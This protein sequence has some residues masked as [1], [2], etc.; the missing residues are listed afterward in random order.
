MK[1]KRE[2]DRHFDLRTYP[3]TVKLGE[4]QLRLL[5]WGV[6]EPKRW[7]NFPHLHSFFECCFVYAGS[8][9]YEVDGRKIEMAPQDLCITTPGQ[10]HSM[11]SADGSDF[12]IFFWSFTLSQEKGDQNLTESSSQF[13]A[14]YA[15]FQQAAEEVITIQAPNLQDTC[16]LITQELFNLDIGYLSAIQGLGQ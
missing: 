4:Y 5:G 10:V 15:D 9:I 14:L 16:R 7:R 8:G 11:R 3:L 6:F 1:G 2:T 13:T 12:G